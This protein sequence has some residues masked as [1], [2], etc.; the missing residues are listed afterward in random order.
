METTVWDYIVI[1]AGNAGVPLASRLLERNRSSKILL[2]E[3]GPETRSRED[4]LNPAP[5]TGDSD[6]SWGYT[7]VAQPTLDNRE[8][9]VSQ[10]KGVGG[11]S[12]TNA[13]KTSPYVMGSLRSP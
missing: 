5:R 4:V 13:C 7:S 12:A 9:L 10:G 3:A 1:G 8:I 11:S 2:I 6:L